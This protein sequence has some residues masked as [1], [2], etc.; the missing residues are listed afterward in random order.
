MV[1]IAMA[2]IQVWPE[3]KQRNLRKI[4]EYIEKAAGEQCDIVVLPECS[5][6]GW[7]NPQ[8]GDEAEP[9]PGKTSSFLC[10]L[11]RKYGIYTACGITE[12]EGEKLYN[13]AVLVN[14]K[15]EMILKH[16]KINI[17]TGIED[18]Y[19]VG[20]SLK[21]VETEFGKIGLA[22]CAD[23][24]AE[25]AVIGHTL[26]RMGC[27]LLLSPS[28]W[29]VTEDF[30][31]EGRIYG[32]EWRVPYQMLSKTY[33]MAVVGVS[34]VG[35]IP[36]GQWQDRCCIGN[37]MASDPEGRIVKELPFGRKAETL[38]ILEVELKKNGLYGT[39]LSEAVYSRI[40]Q[41]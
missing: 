29:A 14:R 7:A 41:N 30:I 17:L 36:F 21:T 34:N 2:Q 18:M 22:I 39:A 28:S 10:E 13:T 4:E 19:S 24:L 16:R 20:D 23:N 40:I 1:K 26:G 31:Q 9:V 15:G 37:S 33:G 3:D 38:G 25:S 8:A 27:Q 32:D 11:S 5:D 6:L 35:E 12:R